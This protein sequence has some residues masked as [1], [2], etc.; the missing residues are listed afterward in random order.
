MNKNLEFPIKINSNNLELKNEVSKLGM[1]KMIKCLEDEE[2][3]NKQDPEEDVFKARLN[4]LKNELIKISVIN[5]ILSTKTSFICVIKTIKDDK[6][7]LI[8]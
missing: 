7:P 8:K 6:T 5:Q 4:D 3:N 1:S 2:F